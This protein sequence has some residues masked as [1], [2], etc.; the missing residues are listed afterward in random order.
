MVNYH[1]AK[2]GGDIM[3]FVCQVILQEHVIKDHVTFWVGAPQGKS[4][5]CQPW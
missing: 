5:F 1:L 2:F 4:P 3:I